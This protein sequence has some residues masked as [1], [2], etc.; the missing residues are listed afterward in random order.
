MDVQEGKAGFARRLNEA[1]DALD[2]PPKQRGRFTAI[3]R[4]FSVSPV[5]A[6]DW[7]EGN[8]YPSVDKLLQIMDTVRC[9]AD[10]LLFGRLAVPAT[11]R[12]ATAGGPA[13][14]AIPIDRYPGWAE[15]R[16]AAAGGSE[17][18]ALHT[19]APGNAAGAAHVGGDAGIGGAAH[20]GGLDPGRLDPGRL[21]EAG[22]QPPGGPPGE[23]HWHRIDGDSMSPTLQ[24]GDWVA[25]QQDPPLPWRDGIFCLQAVNQEP[26]APAWRSQAIAHEPLVRRLVRSVDGRIVVR[27]DNPL[28]QLD[29]GWWCANPV[30]AG[31][32][33]SPGG[34]PRPS[35]LLSRT[36]AV[37]YPPGD[38]RWSVPEQ[39][40]AGAALAGPAD[41]QSLLVTGRVVA[42]QR[43]LR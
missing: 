5:A 40:A 34:V 11:G 12:T 31:P 43:V 29:E 38:Y 28:A 8:S 1:F 2:I 21:G 22:P 6:R 25:L 14:G 20:V 13:A 26:T 32:G 23:V 27:C 3:A 24:P 9:G 37:T 17:G 41:G 10:W 18:D 42:I 16:E 30:Q 35:L 15:G 4:L 39:G 19:V 7:C 33:G 36:P